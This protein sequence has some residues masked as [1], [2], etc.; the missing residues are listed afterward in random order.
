MIQGRDLRLVC[1][2]LEPEAMKCLFRELTVCLQERSLQRLVKI[3]SSQSD[4]FGKHARKI[5][6]GHEQIQPMY[7]TPTLFLHGM[8]RKSGNRKMSS[9]NLHT[10]SDDF[11]PAEQYPERLGYCAMTR[12]EAFELSKK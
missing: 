11:N 8:L 4:K 3:S 6:I 9:A 2:E 12:A 7:M 10:P 5:V 1:E